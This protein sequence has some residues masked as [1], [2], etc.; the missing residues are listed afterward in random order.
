MQA[1]YYRRETHEYRGTLARGEHL[2]PGQ[3]RNVAGGDEL[4]MGTGTAG[5]NDTLRYALAV[6][7]LKLLDQLHIL[8]QG[9]AS[10]AGSLRV[11]VVAYRGAVVAGQRSGEG[12]AGNQH[13]RGE[14]AQC[15]A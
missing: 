10:A 11:L 4:A 3:L 5:M 6:E 15:V 12:A 8:Q 1:V 2:G 14:Y 9:G 7:A 13:G